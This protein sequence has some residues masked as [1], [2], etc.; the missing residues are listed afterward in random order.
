MILLK[1]QYNKIC[2]FL[3]VDIYYFQLSLTHLFKK[4]KH[5][6]L[7]IISYWVLGQVPKLKRTWNLAPVLQIVQKITE[8]YRTCLYLSICQVWW[9][10]ELWF[11]R[12]IQKY[13]LSH[14][15]ILIMTSQ[16]WYLMRW[17]K[18]QKLEYLENGT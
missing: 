5:R 6:N 14:V 18:I 12:Y 10:C 3:M 4:M 9:L 17:L 13:T 7:D 2:P 11:K 1:W 15:L 16:I 8:N